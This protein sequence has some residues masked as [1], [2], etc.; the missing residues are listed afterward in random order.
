MD[1]AT[2]PGA[3]FIDAGCALLG[4][5]LDPAWRPGIEANLRVIL[6]QSAILLDDPLPDAAEPAPVFTA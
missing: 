4:L 2:W 1:D 5:T 3:A 6:S